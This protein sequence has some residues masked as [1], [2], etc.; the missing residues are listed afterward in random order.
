MFLYRLIQFLIR[1]WHSVYTVWIRIFIK[2]VGRRS[3]IQYPCKLQGCGFDNIIIG[4]ESCI[5]SHSIIGCWIKYR[6][7]KGV[8]TFSPKIVI[9]NHC[10]IGEYSQITAINKITIGDGLLTGRYLYIGDNSHGNLSLEE[11][12]IIPLQRPL[13]SKGEITIGR[14]VWIGD[15]V[16]ILGGVTIGDNAIIGANSVVT[17]DIPS[18][19]MAAGMPAKVV[20]Q[21]S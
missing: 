6:T 8:Q 3:V 5:Q 20:K 2:N 12:N 1:I 19:C 11:A 7:Y 14:N 21:L 9:G 18:N 4:E 10:N 17:H 13:L 16:T 15:K